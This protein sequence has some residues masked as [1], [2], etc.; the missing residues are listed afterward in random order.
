MW[1]DNLKKYSWKCPRAGCIYEAIM[2][3]ESS[4]NVAKELHT[5]NHEKNDQQVRADFQKLL[6]AA[7]KDYNR[8]E[9]TAADRVFLKTRGIKAD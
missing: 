2:Y 8:L 6:P 1:H 7:E 4:L 9:L 3:G 5:A